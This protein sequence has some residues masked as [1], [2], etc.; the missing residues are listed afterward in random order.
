MNSALLQLNV[1]IRI[2][3]QLLDM[4]HVLLLQIVARKMMVSHG[5]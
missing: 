3:L 5:S 4:V 1:F 2:P